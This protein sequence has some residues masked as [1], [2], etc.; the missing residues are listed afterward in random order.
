MSYMDYDVDTQE[1]K[2]EGRRVIFRVVQGILAV[3]L[4]IAFVYSS[5]LYQRF[6]YQ[7]TSSLTKQELL[8][9]AIDAE[10]ILLQ[11]TV[12]V[13]RNE[14]SNGS[15]RSQKDVLRLIEEA[16]TIWEQA[17]IEL[18]IQK[19][20]E[21]Q[22]SDREIDVLL[23]SPHLFVQNVEEFAPDT[24]NVFLTENL[25]GINGIAFGGLRTVAV[26]DYTTV[27]DFRALAHEVGHV[28]SLS[29]V[30]GDRGRLMYRGAN[31]FLL[32][33]DE[34]TRAREAA[35]RFSLYEP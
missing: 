24:V 1:E 17:A 31:G 29:H 15:K 28:L 18:T 9:S 34:I 16:S 8:E 4:V 6:F 19:I 3:L 30:Q 12:F 10:T 5:G 32:S 26:A 23:D 22:K 27:Y 13:L 25:R 21:L 33:V 7:R 14:E 11:L 20:V 2:E 35:Q